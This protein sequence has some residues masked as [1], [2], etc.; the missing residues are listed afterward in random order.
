MFL[1]GSRVV[2][3]AASK[4]RSL[5]GLGWLRALGLQT[6][7]PQ[8]SDPD[9]DPVPRHCDGCRVYGLGRGNLDNRR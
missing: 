6:V 5:Q 7:H 2:P 4:A 1:R 8:P 9:N 3:R